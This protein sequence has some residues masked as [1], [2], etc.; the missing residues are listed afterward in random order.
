MNA[1]EAESQLLK[2]TYQLERSN[3]ELDEFAYV[4]SHDLRSPL[5]AV[6]NLAN[7]IRD[8][9]RES[10]SEDSMRHVE[11]MHQRI[12]RMEGLLDDL[13]QYSRVGR[14]QQVI[15]STDVGGGPG[16]NCREPT[17]LGPNESR[18]RF[19]YAGAD[20]FQGSVR[21]CACGI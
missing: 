6:K 12:G 13:L 8:D 21:T 9:N 17:S 4:A 11:L 2:H 20:H 16:N 18:D 10:L 19:R 5:Q 7:W 1:G 14:T 3:Q 15:Q